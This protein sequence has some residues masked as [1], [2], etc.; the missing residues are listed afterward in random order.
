MPKI[1]FN[2]QGYLTVN[3]TPT[4]GAFECGENDELLIAS[5]AGADY[6]P[7]MAKVRLKNGCPLPCDG[8][9][10]IAWQ[11][12]VFS[13]VIKSRRYYPPAP[14]SLRLCRS[15]SCRGVE[16]MLSV[17]EQGGYFFTI[18]TREETFTA[19]IPLE[20]VDSADIYARAIDGGVLI[21][22]KFCAKRRFFFCLFYGS[23]YFP[24]C[25]CL[26][27]E[28]EI[29]DCRALITDRIDDMARLSVTREYAF[30][31]DG[32]ELLSRTFSYR[33]NRIDYPPE[34][35]PY[36]Y[37]ESA[38][39]GDREMCESLSRANAFERF[40]GCL[41]AEPPFKLPLYQTALLRPTRE[42]YSA[43]IYA[44]KVEGGT[45]GSIT[46]LRSL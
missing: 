26:C 31:C 10:T 25:K 11:R 2:A 13:L 39:A 45:I 17:F 18:E 37:C 14:P 28:V 38:L 32:T 5:C 29:N 42:G 23:D 41:L 15:L 3:G 43:E 1:F 46:A 34:L 22:L 12:G 16:H 40:R 19:R 4:A 7:V 21:M 44:F 33:E 36:L 27:D 8:I 24:L 9:K 20:S 30:S 35:L 6:L